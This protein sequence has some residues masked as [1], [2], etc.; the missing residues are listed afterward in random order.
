MS[1]QENV[2]YVQ[3]EWKND[4]IASSKTKLAFAEDLLVE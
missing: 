3:N 2:K 1:T 4:S